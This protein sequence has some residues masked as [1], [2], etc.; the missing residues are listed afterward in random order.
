MVRDSLL[1]IPS[2]ILPDEYRIKWY[3]PGD[4]A[5]WLRIQ[6]KADQYNDITPATFDKAF[7]KSLD[8]LLNRQCFLLDDTDTA[9]GTATAWF[10]DNYNG[11]GYG[12]LH[13]VALIPEKQGRGLSKPLMSTICNQLRELGHERA[14]LTTLSVRIP[15]INLYHKFGFRPEIR[16]V[17]DTKIW[18]AIRSHLKDPLNLV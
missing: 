9:V 1:N 2:Y 14:Y 8:L 15:A 10:N 18:R 17:E 11:V 7:G 6:L 4:E 16:S 3:R 13:W 5:L 12:R